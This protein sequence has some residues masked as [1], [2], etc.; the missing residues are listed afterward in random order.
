MLP[1]RSR[2]RRPWPQRVGSGQVSTPYPRVRPSQQQPQGQGLVQ[3]KNRS[4]DLSSQPV[5]DPG[6]R[7]TNPSLGANQTLLP[8]FRNSNFQEALPEAQ[9]NASH[10][11]S[12]TFA[13]GSV[14]QERPAPCPARCRQLKTRVTSPPARALPQ[15]KPNPEHRASSG[16]SACPQHNAHVPTGTQPPLRGRPTR[17][18]LSHVQPGPT[19]TFCTRS[20]KGTPGAGSEGHAGRKCQRP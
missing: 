14:T 6:T 18:A 7:L 11:S 1:A 3:E 19:K 4:E 8:R 12:V 13:A 15:Q 9:A 5:P 20:G 2:P 16:G 17:S 10:P